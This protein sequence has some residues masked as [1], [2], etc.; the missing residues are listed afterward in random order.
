MNTLILSVALITGVVVIL[1]TLYI[2]LTKTQITAAQSLALGVGAS[3]IVLTFIGSAMDMERTIKDAVKNATAQADR[4]GIE[5][6][7][8]RNNPKGP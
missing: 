1:S 5:E 6:Y 2:C 3:L 7:F 4:E 8:N